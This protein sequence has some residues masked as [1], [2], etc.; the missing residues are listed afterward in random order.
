MICNWNVF[1][2]TNA[3]SDENLHWSEFGSKKWSN[4][5]S[6]YFSIAEMI[7]IEFEFVLYRKFQV[8]LFRLVWVVN[9]NKSFFVSEFVK[10]MNSNHFIICCCLYF[11]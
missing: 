7:L 11:D 6:Y 1:V 3:N 2:D 4:F 8:C 5:K 9:E 10:T